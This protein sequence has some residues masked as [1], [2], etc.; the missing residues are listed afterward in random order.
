MSLR[1]IHPG[2]AFAA[3]ADHVYTTESG[4]E[5]MVDFE[6]VGGGSTIFRISGDE[7]RPPRTRTAPR[8]VSP[9]GDDEVSV[10]IIRVPE[11]L[12]ASAVTLSGRV[13][14]LAGLSEQTRLVPLPQDDLLLVSSTDTGHS[15]VG[16]I[17]FE[18]VRPKKKKEEQNHSRRGSTIDQETRQTLRAELSELAKRKVDAPIDPEVRK[19]VDERFRKALDR[20]RY[21]N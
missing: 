4:M 2:D 1:V 13:L 7:W 10:S 6:T 11:A 3:I 5:V 14:D 21:T 15:L 17:V 18:V 12:L 8:T 9:A 20:L 16:E 19:D